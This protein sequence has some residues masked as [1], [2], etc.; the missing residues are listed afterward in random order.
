MQIGMVGLAVALTPAI[1]ALRPASVWSDLCLALAGSLFVWS[2]LGLWVFFDD[3]KQYRKGIEQE[4][5]GDL[6]IAAVLL[7]PAATFFAGAQ[8][9]DAPSWIEVPLRVG[10]VPPFVLGLM[11][12]ASALDSLFIKPRLKK[13]GRKQPP[14]QSKAE[15][16][17]LIGGIATA[18]TWGLTN[19]AS[20]LA[21]IERLSASAN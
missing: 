14:G 16:N 6:I 1:L 2:M 17:S 10:A 15:R 19:A 12:V 21:I 18:T 20:F 5:W 9:L 4:G 7:A 8:I 13:L 3:I 11:F